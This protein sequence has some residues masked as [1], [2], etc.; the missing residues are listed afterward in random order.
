MNL[1]QELLKATPA[2]HPDYAEIQT[3]ATEIEALVAQLNEKKRS[4]ET[5]QKVLE[6]MTMVEGLDKVRTSLS[7]CIAHAHT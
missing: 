5:Q 3:A 4:T 1:L 2:D 6:L 7:L